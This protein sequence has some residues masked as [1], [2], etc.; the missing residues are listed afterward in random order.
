MVALI[1]LRHGGMMILQLIPFNCSFPPQRNIAR[2]PVF[3]A[4]ARSWFPVAE[5]GNASSYQLVDVI[6][7][8]SKLLEITPQVRGEVSVTLATSSLT[9]PVNIV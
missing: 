9:L 1:N 4:V 8:G 3:T 5:M 2:R 7:H 6:Q